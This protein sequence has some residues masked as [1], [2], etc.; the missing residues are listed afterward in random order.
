MVGAGKIGL[1]SVPL[2][3]TM[4]MGRVSPLFCG[5]WPQTAL[6]RR[7]DRRVS[8]M[9]TSTVPSRGMLI[10]RS[11]TCGAVPMRSTT[12]SLPRTVIAT[13]NGRFFRDASLSSR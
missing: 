3:A 13:H 10:G 1:A 11:G 2:G 8:Q 9:A 12:S 4:V 7:M 5:M 6:S